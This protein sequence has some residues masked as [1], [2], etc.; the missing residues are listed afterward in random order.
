[1]S[2]LGLFQ[3]LFAPRQHTV[4]NP[5][6]LLF[7]QIR[8]HGCDCGHMPTEFME[9]PHGGLCVNIF[10][11]HCGQGYNV[12]PVAEWAERIHVDK[13]YV[14]AEASRAD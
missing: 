5:A 6:H 2:V 4:E 14:R 3:R 7:V 11:S 1:M 9:G 12:T 13:T 8:D 10:C